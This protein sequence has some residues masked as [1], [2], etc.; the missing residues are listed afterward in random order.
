MAM[1]W[2]SDQKAAIDARNQSLLV[3]AAAGSGKTAVLKERIIE[4]LKDSSN[5]LSVQEL[6][7]TTFTKAAA[8]EM[9]ARIGKALA[10]ELQRTDLDGATRDYLE[11]QLGLLPSAQIS[12][13]HAFCQ[14]VIK[15]YFYV[16]H[17][18]PA[19]RIGNDGEMALMRSEVLHELLVDLYDRVG[20]DPSDD[21]YHMYDLADMFSNDKSDANL[22]S[23][24]LQ[25]YTFAMAL[26]RPKKWLQGAVE[27]YREIA[28]SQS[29]LETKWGSHFWRDLEESMAN[30]AKQLKSFKELVERE[31]G[32]PCYAEHY[33]R[34]AAKFMP[35][36]AALEKGSWDDLYKAV[37]T[38]D[39]SGYKQFR[40]SQQTAPYAPELKAQAKTYHNAIKDYLKDLKT[41][42]FALS[43]A[44]WRDQVAEQIPLMEGLV[45]LTWAFKE[46]YDKA[47]HDAGLMDFSD[48]EHMCLQILTKP[49]GD[50]DEGL[51]A[52]DVA[53][54]LQ[55]HFK[56]IMVDEY[57]D[58]SGVQ[59][60]IINL[61]STERNRFYVGD[62]KQSI[63]S[64]RMADSD[65]FMSKYKSF[66]SA[67]TAGTD[68]I[69]HVA[70]R[71]ID[72]AK[73]FRSHKNV[74]AVT[75]FIFYQI[76]TET[77]AELDY[78][79]KEALVAGREVEDPPSN[80]IGGPAE[81]L[82][83]DVAKDQEGAP[84]SESPSSSQESW[85]AEDDSSED[86]DTS[87]EAQDLELAM[88]IDEIKKYMA[89]DEKGNACYTV[90]DPDGHFRPIQYKDIVILRRSLAGFGNRM[91]E[92]M[93]NANIPAYVEEKNGYFESM[94]IQLLLSLLQIIDNPEQDLPMAAVL[95]SPMVGL[96][97]E[98]IGSLRI[99]GNG[100]LWSLLPAY[101]E[102]NSLA[103]TFVDRMQ[104]W[105]TLSRRQGVADL[106]WTIYEEL[107]YVNYVSAL[108]NGLVRRANV[109]ALLSRAQEFENGSFK[110]LFRFLRFVESLRDSGQDMALAKVVSEAD[111]VVRIM[112]IHKS[113]GLE[114]PLVF[115]SGMQ[116]KFNTMDLKSSVLLHKTGGIGLKGYYPE[117]RVMYPSLGSLYNYDCKL[118]AL[119]AEEERI[120]YV[121][122]TRARDKLVMTASFDNRLIGQTTRRKIQDYAD[123]FVKPALAEEG[124]QLPKDLILKA[125]SYLDWVVMAFA[126]HLEGGN[127]LR[128]ALGDE[129]ADMASA[130]ILNEAIPDRKEARISVEIRPGILYGPLDR[131]SHVNQDVIERVRHMEDF[132]QDS[133]EPEVERRF[134]FSYEAQEAT[135]RAAKISVTEIKRRFEEIEEEAEAFVASRGEKALENSIFA[136]KPAFLS[137]QEKTMTGAQRGT[138][139]HGVMQWLPIAA[140]TR[141]T[142]A[143]ALDQL[144]V[145]SLDGKSLNNG[146]GRLS[147]EERADLDEN[148]LLTF[149][150]SDLAARMRA[151][152]RVERELPFSMLYEGQKVYESLEGES[153]FLQGIIDAC[154]L[155]DDQWVLVD[156][157][158]DR[159][160]SAEAFKERY[161]K[162][163]EVYK[164]ALESIT[165]KPV[166]ET[167]IYS[168]RLGQAI[169]LDL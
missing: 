92:A 111:D 169:L 121:A 23:M 24:I 130:D 143:Q 49:G 149:F 16:A 19:A 137:K 36:Q 124:R 160:T 138:L 106:L 113:K 89:K 44:S 55:D 161:H 10:E 131:S 74:L 112:T 6:L 32:T 154:F 45:G 141:E 69:D 26:A 165:H 156:Y 80:W 2:T 140:Y 98:D 110:G 84:A 79:E 31:D 129:R 162:Q 43:E 103:K 147:Q 38:Y 27:D 33:D 136:T 96:S 15:S 65:L 7:V 53:L 18:N 151:S 21:P 3:A 28:S 34:V 57:Q 97:A 11:K 144:T 139:M 78:G 61:I 148:A 145:Q 163:L 75:N 128:N 56:E 35:F 58:T 150:Q 67:D 22:E 64:F 40:E 134:A 91:V 17:I 168:F 30:L 116:K 115:L 47:K 158:T 1:T 20:K 101:A 63:Y 82:L 142:L 9:R 50:Q 48:L 4:R 164:E 83:V 46:A 39:A 85:G 88:I 68:S 8:G 77:A 119:K 108:P 105:R 54:E 118:K 70:E 42:V 122:L 157:K 76:M 95:H 125:N 73:N 126:R 13:L 81:L 71:R 51:E 132:R 59:E 127:L 37:V 166:K 52:S 123:K 159:L 152:K 72:L 100:S 93:R 120:L 109:M 25:I 90:Q 87:P 117:Y 62:V 12:T 133:L 86:Q 135:Q 104:N 66:T 153:L 146:Q 94:E 60:A 99:S 14:W 114:F 102:T 41:S 167:Y 107:D 29:L 155:E 5:P